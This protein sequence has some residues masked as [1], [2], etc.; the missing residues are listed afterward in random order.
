[1]GHSAQGGAGLPAVEG[2]A[3]GQMAGSASPASPRTAR[4]A[5]G[6]RVPA[7]A[8]GSGQRVARDL[9]G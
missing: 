1:M 5:G 3:G 9:A 7:S 4:V 8:S 2:G 6:L